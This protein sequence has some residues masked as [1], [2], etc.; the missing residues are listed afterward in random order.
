M[1][2]KAMELLLNLWIKAGFLDEA[3]V[4]F[5]EKDVHWR[6]TIPMRSESNQI[7]D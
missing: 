5:F 3:L 4:R 6:D 2:H 1:S 7:R